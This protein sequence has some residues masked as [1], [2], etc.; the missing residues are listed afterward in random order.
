MLA[1]SIGTFSSK[2]KCIGLDYGQLRASSES[3]LV[4]NRGFN[5]LSLQG[6][7][8]ADDR[9]DRVA[10]LVKSADGCRRNPS[11][12]DDRRIANHIFVLLDVP[13]LIFLTRSEE[14]RVGE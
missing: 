7:V 1:T 5:I 11:A 9:F 12:G 6:R 8:L 2:M 10:R 4:R 14:R 3:F 13:E